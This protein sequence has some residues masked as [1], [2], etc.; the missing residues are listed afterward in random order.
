MSAPKQA[1]R[2][3]NDPSLRRQCALLGLTRSGSTVPS[4]SRGRTIGP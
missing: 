2:L 4:L 3:G 1:G